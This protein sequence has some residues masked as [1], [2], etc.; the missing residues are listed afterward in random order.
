[1][2]ASLYKG[3]V[4]IEFDEAKHQYFLLPKRERLLGVTTATGIIDKSTPLIIWA[5]R[6]AADYLNE[7][8]SSGKAVTPEHIAEAINQ[9]RVK[10][11][12][13]ADTGTK[14]HDWIEHF[15]NDKKTPALPTDPQE[16]NGVTAF[17]KWVDENDVEFIESETI[18]YSK[19][20]KYVGKLDAI[21]KV[22]KKLTMV[23]YKSSKGIYSNFLYQTALYRGAKEEETGWNFTGD[24]V[25]LKLGKDD[26]EFHAHQCS[27]FERDFKAGIACVIAKKRE[28]ELTKLIREL[29]YKK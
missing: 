28:N 22:N 24:R 21:A 14:I 19:K 1:M 8:L 16:L 26:G 17:L 10:K 5:T 23:D 6:L 25:I 18:V 27:E 20:Y 3:T 2:I 7:I 9:H 4:Q 13:A 29:N 11:D 12:T 15:I